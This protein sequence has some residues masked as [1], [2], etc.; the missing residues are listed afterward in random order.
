MPEVKT[1]VTDASVDDFLTAIDNPLRQKDAARICALMARVSGQPPRMW[2]DNIVGFGSY[3]YVQ[4]DGSKA[5]WPMIGFSPRKANLTIYVMPGFADYGGQ[6]AKLGSHKVSKSCLYLTN[7]QKN[8]LDALE[9]I[10]RA[11]YEWMRNKYSVEK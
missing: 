9:T 5:T 3:S 11:S 8:D 4:R 1:K 10:V 7:L 6:L 2:G